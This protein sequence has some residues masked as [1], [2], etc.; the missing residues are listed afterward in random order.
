MIGLD[1]FTLLVLIVHF[2]APFY[3]MQDE[4]KRIPEK[5]ISID[6]CKYAIKKTTFTQLKL[7]GRVLISRRKSLYTNKFS[8]SG[9][10]FSGLGS[11]F[12]TVA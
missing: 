9:T 5:Q 3:I 11:A 12:V 2:L 6:L 1:L 10:A 7:K 4:C 8:C